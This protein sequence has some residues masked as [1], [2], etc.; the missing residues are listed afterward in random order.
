MTRRPNGAGIGGTFWGR[1]K[2]M[3]A[4]RRCREKCLGPARLPDRGKI[5]YRHC[6]RTV[7]AV[8]LQTLPQSAHSLPPCRR[9]Q[10]M[11]RLPQSGE[12]PAA[13]KTDAAHYFGRQD[14]EF[15]FLSYADWG[16]LT[17]SLGLPLRSKGKSSLTLP[18]FCKRKPGAGRA[19]L[20][21]AK[22]GGLSPCAPSFCRSGGRAFPTLLPRRALSASPHNRIPRTGTNRSSSTRSFVIL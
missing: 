12:S 20:S 2:N 18:R 17:I 14:Q 21:F 4:L 10:R 1:S 9:Q 22:E 3:F 15:A 19:G 8:L 13:C 7:R 11:V 16:E 6:Y 5:F